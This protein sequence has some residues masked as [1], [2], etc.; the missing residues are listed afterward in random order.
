MVAESIPAR[1]RAD[2]ASQRPRR[3]PRALLVAFVTAALAGV[4]AVPIA[5]NAGADAGDGLQSVLAVGGPGAGVDRVDRV[6]KAGPLRAVEETTGVHVRVAPTVSTTVTFGAPVAISVEIENATG[7]ALAP[8]VVRLLRAGGAI[9]D[10]AEL[11]EWLGTD[12][13]SGDARTAVPLA[14]SESRGLAAGGAMV[15][16]FAVPGEAFADLADAAVVGLGAEVVVGDTVVASGADVYAN[17]DVP[18]AG[19]VAVALVAPLTAPVTGGASGLIEAGQLENWTGPTGLLTRQLDALAGRQVAIGLDP[20]IIASIRVLGSSA[21]ASATAWL[22]RLANVPNEVFPLAYAD[23]DLAVQAQLGLPAVLGPT[24]FTDALDPANFSEPA[25][26]DAE[27]GSAGGAGAE[28][29]PTPTEGPGEPQPTPGAVPTDEQVLEWPYTR[30]DIAWPA[31]DTVGTGNLSYFDAAGLTT[32]LLAPGNVEPAEGAES[33]ATIEGST[34]LVADAGLTSPLREASVASTDTEWRAATGRLLAELALDAGVARTTVLATFDRGAPAQSA[35]VATLIDEI[36]GSPWS[37]LAGLSDAIGAPPEARTLIDEPESEER[38]ASVERMVGAEA[39][40]TQFATV[41]ADEDLLTGPVRR[42]LLALLDVAWLEDREGW[43]AAIDAWLTSQAETLEAVSVVP[44]STVNVLSRESPLPTT[45]QNLLPY[46]VTV[47]VN[48]APS[49][50]RLIV[51][52]EMEVTVEPE[53]RSTV[54]VPV[55]A[56][57]GN[58]EVTLTVSLSST[59]GVPVGSPTQIE[60]NVQADW[61]GLGAGILATIAVLVFGIG[62]W[63]NIRRRRRERAAL[64]IAATDAPDASD[65]AAD[66]DAATTTDA[67]DT[68][69]AAATTDAETADDADTTDDE[70]SARD[71]IDAPPAPDPQD[72]PRG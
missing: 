60:A 54:N 15:V 22:Q 64:A 59:T 41:L 36:A 48:V 7:E 10:E 67:A 72:R 25:A 38:R 9:D 32:A 27:G 42:E 6:A 29:T 69:D 24:T 31:D 43:N 68:S 50:G 61:E 51:E 4:V 16:S 44:S 2:S 26:D 3:R 11:D 5:A 14:E 28:P 63:R 65:S 56:G 8:G 18:A 71:T 39:D 70:A 62:I 47:V 53:S 23:A 55:A 20:R 30:T 1:R 58:G 35:R 19:H 33:S 12:A 37:A 21:P 34:A 66:A 57:V 46:P 52:D 40:V 45:V 49:N 13:E 17:A